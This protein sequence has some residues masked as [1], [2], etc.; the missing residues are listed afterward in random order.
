VVERPELGIVPQV[1]K[2]G[3]MPVLELLIMPQAEIL[4]V[5]FCSLHISLVLV[6]CNCS[7]KYKN[8]KTEN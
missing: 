4:L 3:K 8:F 5:F 1:K 2:R 7:T 6:S